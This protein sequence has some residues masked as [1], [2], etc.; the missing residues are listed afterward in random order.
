VDS[1]NY[2]FGFMNGVGLAQFIAANDSLEAAKPEFIK[3]VNKAI[4]T[5]YEYPNLVL[6]GEQFGKQLQSLDTVGYFDG[7][8][9]T[10][11]YELFKQG[12]IN[13]LLG[14]DKQMTID[15]AEAYLQEVMMNITYK[16]SKIEGAKYLEE[17]GKREG[18][19]TT[20]SGLQYEVIKMGNGE[21]PTATDRVKVHYHGTLT[22][23]TVFDSS[24]ERGDPIIFAL[25]QVISGWTE[26]LQLMPVGSKFK[27]FVPYNLAYGSQGQGQIPPFSTLIF[28]VE[29]LEIVK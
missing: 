9:I 12:V 16:E 27:F 11:N 4:S 3:Y 10:A 25:T 15:V 19:T 26:G 6:Q 2:A 24:V 18:V 23:G 7:A 13:G 17:N 21:K 14:A 5:K 28:E 29:L 8:N 22:N 20:A 1:L